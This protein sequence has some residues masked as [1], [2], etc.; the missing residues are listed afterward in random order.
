MKKMMLQQKSRNFFDKSLEKCVTQLA[1]HNCGTT[2]LGLEPLV[3]SGG[4]GGGELSQWQEGTILKIKE[5]SLGTIT[6]N[7]SSDRSKSLEE[8]LV[9]TEVFTET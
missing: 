1:Q 9:F 7:S 5:R 6:T 3:F 2:V 4:G 8:E